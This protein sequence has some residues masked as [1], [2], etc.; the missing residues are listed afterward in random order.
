MSQ[1]ISMPSRNNVLLSLIN[2]ETAMLAGKSAAELAQ[3]YFNIVNDDTLVMSPAI[4][5]VINSIQALIS[6]GDKKAWE[7]AEAAWWTTLSQPQ[8]ETPARAQDK[9]WHLNGQAYYGGMI[10]PGEQ[11]E[12]NAYDAKCPECQKNAICTEYERVE[13]G[14]MNFYQRWNCPHCGYT[15]DNGAYD[16]D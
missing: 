7:A 16:H 9:L 15:A 4:N 1:L 5:D 13:G 14:A 3:E 11:L 6:R 10:C 12:P 8:Q 2:I